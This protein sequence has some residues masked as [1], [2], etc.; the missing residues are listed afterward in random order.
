MMT[1]WQLRKKYGVANPNFRDSY[2]P[3]DRVD[4]V[5]APLIV[6]KKLEAE[7]PM[8]TKDKIRREGAKSRLQREERSLIK[9]LLD[10]KEK[11]AIY[12][13]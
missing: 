6:P 8:K 9:P 5:F 1:T 13:I 10:E 3:I 7:L 2:K 11:Q 4:K 12:F